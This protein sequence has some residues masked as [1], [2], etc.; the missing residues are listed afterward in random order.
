AEAKGPVLIVWRGKNTATA[1][2]AVMPERF[3]LALTAAG[4]ALQE[5]GSLSRHLARE[6]RHWNIRPAVSAD[7]PGADDAEAECD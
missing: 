1:A 6:T 4:I 2:D 5:I 3:S 7:Q